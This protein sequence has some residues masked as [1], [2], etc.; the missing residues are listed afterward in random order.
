MSVQTHLSLSDIERRVCDIAAKQLGIKREKVSPAS[1]LFQD[2]HC[3][4]LELVEL[5]MNLE[6]AF[7]VTLPD[8]T[9]LP[10][11]KALFVRNPICLSDVAEFVYLQQGTGQPPKARGLFGRGRIVEPPVVDRLPFTQLGGKWITAEHANF[12]R[13]LEPI[14]LPAGIQQF[15]RRSDGMR[16]LLLP[17]VEV[18][19]GS[20]DPAALPD[21]EPLHVVALDPFLIDAEP[22]STTAFCRFL[23]SIIADETQLADWFVLAEEDRREE[24]MPITFSHDHW[25]P[26]LGM[27]LMPMVLVSWYG[28]NAYSCWANGQSCEDYRTSEGFLP[29]E[30]E[31]EYAARGANS[32]AFSGGEENAAG[33]SMNCAQHMRG[34]VYS[35]ENMPLAA[36]HERLGMSP[37]GLHHMAGNVWQWCRD[38]Y[39]ENFYHQPESQARNPVNRKPTGIRSE[40]GGSWVGPAKL[41][42]SSYR[43][44]RIPAARGRCLGFRCISPVQIDETRDG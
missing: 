29:S 23:N 30:A 26:V 35:A 19:I 8:A 38:W 17:A 7:G 9:E 15:R 21:E 18:E 40:R 6:E 20:R 4:S 34:E 28:A 2:L 42:R 14:D 27:E 22:V 39:D 12:T 1:R 3:D 24:Q 32:Q 41:C 31:W 10:L 36:V 16:C 13:L 37:F 11:G 5:M 43:R 44:G 33:E 25:Q